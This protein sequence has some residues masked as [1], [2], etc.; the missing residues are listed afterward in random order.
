MNKPTNDNAQHKEVI[1]THEFTAWYKSKYDYIE[2]FDDNDTSGSDPFDSGGLINNQLVFIE[3]KDRITL[4]QIDYKGSIGS[5]IEKKIG[6]L[7]TQVYY[8]EA[9]KSYQSVADHYTN[10]TRPKIILVVNAISTKSTDRLLNMLQRKSIDWH[11]SYELIKWNG[12]EGI[13]LFE[14]IP[15]FNSKILNDQI[16]IPSFPN[17]A[18]KRTNKLSYEKVC[19]HME[20]IDQSDNF[21]QIYSFFK[22]K[23]A[24]VIWNATCVNMKFLKFNGNALLGIWI[25]K[26]TKEDG[27]LVTYSLGLL[28]EYFKVG[29]NTEQELK[30]QRNSFKVGN[31]GYNAFL[32]TSTEVSEFLKQL[33]ANH[34]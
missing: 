20:S 32:K 8:K 13:T 24:T 22:D 23:K 5:S 1:L 34:L 12:K 28:L 6:Q 4:S 17:T 27:I 9:T 15:E 14:E 30:L 16:V 11:F 31:L 3:F 33:N 18:L 29:I 25:H 10:T 2:L 26:S 19:A 21:K 7:L